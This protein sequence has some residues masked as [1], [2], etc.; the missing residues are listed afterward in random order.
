MIIKNV[1]KCVSKITA[2]IDIFSELHKRDKLTPEGKDFKQTF[3][4]CQ[5]KS[6]VKLSAFNIHSQ[7]KIAIQRSVKGEWNLFAKVLPKQNSY[8]E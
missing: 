7:A 2:A 1:F 5:H 6:V 8:T 4:L 3:N